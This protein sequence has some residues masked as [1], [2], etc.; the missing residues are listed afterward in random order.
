VQVAPALPIDFPWLGLLTTGAVFA[1]MLALGLNLGREQLASLRPRRWLL[2]KVLF[3]VIVVVPALAAL[4]LQLV[5]VRGAVAAGIVLM[6]ISP[7]APVALR[8]ALDAGGDPGFAPAMHLVIVLLAVL[9]VPASVAVLD[10]IYDAELSVTPLHIG[11]QVFFA[12]LMPLG[13]GAA[14]RAVRP[15]LAARLAAPLARVGNGLLIVVVLAVL[16]DGP[17]IV[18]NT[19]WTPIVAGVVFTAG[20]LAIGAAAA[21]RDAPVRPAAAIAAAMRNPGLAIVIATANGMPTDVVTTVLG[22][23]MGLGLSLTA[24]LLWRRQR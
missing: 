23:A 18:A 19:G 21:W 7:G 14:L 15:G 4:A 3:A 5:G 6:V 20:A 8:R 16:V 11:R 12:Q 17:A 13:I 10:R 1:V 22:Y 24:Y 2:L 9:T